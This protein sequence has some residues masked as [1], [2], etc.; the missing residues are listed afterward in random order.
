MP[1]AINP[2]EI[3]IKAKKYTLPSFE[4][5]CTTNSGPTLADDPA[6][7]LSI[8]KQKPKTDSQLALAQEAVNDKHVTLTDKGCWIVKSTDDETPYA[9]RL[10]PKEVC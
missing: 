5:N 8:N 6:L 3:A 7:T 1:K 10:F 2:K 4:E 9:V